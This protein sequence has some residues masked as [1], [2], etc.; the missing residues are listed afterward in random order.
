MRNSVINMNK[1]PLDTLLI[2]CLTEMNRD[3][4]I[5]DLNIYTYFLISHT[6]L[7]LKLSTAGTLI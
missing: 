4:E 2:W 3:N 7:L 5:P 6:V 1:Q